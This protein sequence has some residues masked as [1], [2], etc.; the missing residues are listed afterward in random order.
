MKY[1]LSL[2]TATALAVA[3]SAW[4]G[5]SAETN[6]PPTLADQIIRNSRDTS[7]VAFEAGAA[8]AARAIWKNPNLTN[9]QQVIEAAWVEAKQAWKDAGVKPPINDP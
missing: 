3:C 6:N 2:L 5:V 9:T 4:L 8:M 7:K 1:K